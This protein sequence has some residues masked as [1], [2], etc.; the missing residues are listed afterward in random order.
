MSANVELVRSIFA[1][2]ER[3]DFSHADWADPG[4]EIVAA[5]GPE[6]GAYTGHAGMAAGWRAFLAAW[7]DY[8]VEADEYLELDVER[9]LV[10]VNHSGRAKVSEVEIGQTRAGASLFH[11][12]GGTVT[13]L[14]VYF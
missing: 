1:D 5:D 7:E 12:R 10:L 4:I 8:R 9:V 3:G 6:P 13:E 14:L 11:I 2:W